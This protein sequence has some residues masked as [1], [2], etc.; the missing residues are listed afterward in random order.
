MLRQYQQD[1]ID[2]IIG[3]HS[4]GN[5]PLVV[6][7]T[8]TGKTH[9]FMEYARRTNKRVMIVAERSEIVLQARD[10]LRSVGEDVDVLL[11]DKV[12]R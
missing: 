1:A 7:A 3:S 5:R 11:F 9:V 2:G 10:K 6:M 8:G 4:K 12:K